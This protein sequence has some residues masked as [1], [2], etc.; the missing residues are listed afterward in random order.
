MVQRQPSQRCSGDTSDS[1]DSSHSLWV[2]LRCWRMA[3]RSASSFGRGLLLFCSSCTSGAR[4]RRSASEAGPSS[5]ATGRRILASRRYVQTSFFASSIMIWRHHGDREVRR[6]QMSC[7]SAGSTSPARHGRSEPGGSAAWRSHPASAPCSANWSSRRMSTS[8]S[9]CSRVWCP[10]WRSIAQPPAIHQGR[11]NR[12]RT[13][14]ASAGVIGSHGPR[15]GCTRTSWQPWPQS[16]A[17]PA[18]PAA[19]TCSRASS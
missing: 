4:T 6:H 14:D 19:G 7:T 1:A 9:A 2:T 12:P 18:Q 5:A 10:R 11:C 13:S 8:M 17:A 16:N 15:F 3:R